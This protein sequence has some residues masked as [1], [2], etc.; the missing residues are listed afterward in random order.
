MEKKEDKPAYTKDQMVTAIRIA[1]EEGQSWAETYRGWFTPSREDQHERLK[2]GMR[3][4]K[5]AIEK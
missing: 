2:R 4:I 5:R 3:R 1:F